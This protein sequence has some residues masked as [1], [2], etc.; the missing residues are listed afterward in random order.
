VAGLI[1]ALQWLITERD[2]AEQN[3]RFHTMQQLYPPY[4]D[5][6]PFGR[7]NFMVW[8]F[9]AAVATALLLMVYFLAA[10][11]GGRLTRRP[12]DGLFAAGLAAVVSSL[13][14]AVSTRAAI[15]LGPDPLTTQGHLVYLPLFEGVLIIGFIF[16]A[17]GGAFGGAS[18]RPRPPKRLVSS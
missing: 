1:G 3:A 11:V 10:Y 16:I 17:L 5:F 9:S 13:L 7:N 4:D 6:T 18:A 2:L 8:F 14:Y 12:R 15:E